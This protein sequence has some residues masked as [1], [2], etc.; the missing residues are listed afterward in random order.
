MAAHGNEQMEKTIFR[1]IFHSL[2]IKLQAKA[3]VLESFAATFCSVK[4]VT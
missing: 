2:A 1:L 4:T 3:D